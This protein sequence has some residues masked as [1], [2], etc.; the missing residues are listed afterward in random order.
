VG[1]KLTV[2]D[3]PL[4][5]VDTAMNINPE[6]TPLLESSYLTNDADAFG[7]LALPDDERSRA[8]EIKMAVAFQN[9]SCTRCDSSRIERSLCISCLA[10]VA[11]YGPEDSPC[12][13][14]GVAPSGFQHRY[15]APPRFRLAALTRV[16]ERYRDFAATIHGGEWRDLYRL[17][18]LR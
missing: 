17:C 6:A 13:N 7:I 15:I 3:S 9:Q 8:Y 11:L 10:I 2:S 5:R 4:R 1:S 18:L 16:N 14:R 12:P